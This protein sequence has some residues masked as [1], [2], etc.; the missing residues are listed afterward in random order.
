MTSRPHPSNSFYY[1]AF[2]VV[3]LTSFDAPKTRNNEKPDEIF[4]ILSSLPVKSR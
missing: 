4:I 2:I 3:R 1:S